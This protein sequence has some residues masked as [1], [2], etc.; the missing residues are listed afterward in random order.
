MIQ[1]T[2]GINNITLIKNLKAIPTNL[3][4]QNLITKD[5]YEIPCIDTGMSENKMT[6]EFS[7]FYPI[8]GEYSYEVLDSEGNIISKGLAKVEQDEPKIVIYE[9]QNTNIVYEGQL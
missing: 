6:I 8:I 4:L 3:K 2:S 7:Y 9:T 5:I 1:I